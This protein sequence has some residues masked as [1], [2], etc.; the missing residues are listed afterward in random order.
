LSKIANDLRLL[1]S[2]PRGGLNEINLPSVQPGSSIMPGKVNP[3]IPEAVNQTC[4][5]VVGNDLAITMAAEAGQLQLNFSEPLI[6]YNILSS[7]RMM[8]NACNMLTERCIR[9]ITA[10][11]E[12]C[13]ALVNNSI[14]IVTAFNP[15]I[16][17]EVSTGIAKK[18]LETGRS[19][20]DLIREEKLL[21]DAMINDIMKKENLTGPSSL[22]SSKAVQDVDR[23]FTHMT[24]DTAKIFAED[25]NND[26]GYESA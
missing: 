5:Q 17:Y 19:V 13:R 7:L 26:K 12:H 11:T 22:I 3:V 23:C 6:I 15:F 21:D 2:G 24:F 10:N 4:F 14:G 8:T 20:L 16:G 18:A 9:G 25:E 1:S